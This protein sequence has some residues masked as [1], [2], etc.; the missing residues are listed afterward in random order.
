MKLISLSSAHKQIPNMSLIKS[1]GK[2]RQHA[3]D[4]QLTIKILALLNGIHV[5]SDRDHCCALTNVPH[6]KDDV[7]AGRQS[8]RLTGVGEGKQFTKEMSEKGFINE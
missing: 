8:C 3:A 1:D 6:Y 5:T 7:N 4:L 2:Q